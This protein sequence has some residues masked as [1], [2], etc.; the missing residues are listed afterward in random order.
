MCLIISLH[1]YLSAGF[2]IDHCDFVFWF[3]NFYLRIWIKLA[4]LCSDR[5]YLFC[6]LYF[7]TWIKLGVLHAILIVFD[8]DYNDCFALDFYSLL[9]LKC[10]IYSIFFSKSDFNS[11]SFDSSEGD[12]LIM[13]IYIFSLYKISLIFVEFNNSIID[14]YG[15]YSSTSSKSSVWY[16]LYSFLDFPCPYLSAVTGLNTVV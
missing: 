3:C 14:D 10:Y 9:E 8:S 1:F 15:C 7:Y 12:P 5:T 4:I 16:S 6:N 13:T 11:N 2:E